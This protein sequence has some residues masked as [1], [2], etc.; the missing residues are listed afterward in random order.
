MLNAYGRVES[1]SS[2]QD[3]VFVLMIVL[4]VRLSWN[5]YIVMAQKVYNVV[6]ILVSL[7]IY[8]S[9]FTQKKKKKGLLSI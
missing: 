6:Y 1:D 9:P 4:H 2:L 3:V 8:D 7:L 5:P